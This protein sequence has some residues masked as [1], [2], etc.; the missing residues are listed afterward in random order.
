MKRPGGFDRGPEDEELWERPRPRPIPLPAS[1][2]GAPRSGGGEEDA[3]AQQPESLEP[4][5]PDP[6]IPDPSPMGVEL[7]PHDAPTRE[8]APLDE[9]AGDP[10]R[11]AKRQL[12]RAQ[13]AVRLRERREQ[14][15]FTAHVRRRRRA[16]LIACGAVL[17]L[18][19]FVAVGVLSP[20]TAVRE[21]RVV[22]A[23][24]VDVAGLERALG[25]F[26]GVPLALVQESDVHR[27]LEPFPLIQRY[28]VERIPPH[29]LLVRIQERDAVIAVKRGDGFE[30][31]D[32]AAVL[33]GAAEQPPKGVPVAKG[34]VTDPSTPA[35]T[36][37]ARIVRDLPEDIRKKLVRV[38]ANSA[39]DVAFVL[40]DG[41]RVV[42]GE[43][44]ETQRKAVVLRAMLK[45]IKSARIIDVSAPD[46][47]VFQ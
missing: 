45:S 36:A 16:W 30:M 6:G 42:W 19:L 35:F 20:L 27:V 26:E 44:G 41:K 21:V 25:R 13:R 14:R 47:P 4:G 28:S 24:R 15:R 39:Q 32:P 5:L 22:G 23:E 12:K 46:T 9:P 38:S 2:F 37:A 29:T 7:E 43:A 1:P 34:R 8:L 18:A 31:L 40:A 33:V 11:V 3:A 10:I 17:G